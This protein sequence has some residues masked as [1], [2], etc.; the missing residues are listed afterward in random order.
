MYKYFGFGLNIASEIEMPE[1][2][3]A[4]FEVH[5]ILISIGT[6]PDSVSEEEVFSKWFFSLGKSEYILKIKDIARYYAK[7]GNTIIIQPDANVEADL[8][9][10]RVFLLGSVMGV[11]LHQRGR[12]PMHASAIS[13][14]GQLILFMG[15]SGAGKS[16][17][18]ANLVKSGYNAFTD[19]ICILD[20]ADNTTVKGA[21]AYPLIK[22]WGDAV[23][24]VDEEMFNTDYNLRPNLQKYGQFFHDKFD[25]RE[26]PVSKL[27]ILNP[28]NLVNELTCKELSGIEAFKAVEKQAYRY[29]LLTGNTM[30]PK[31]FAIISALLQNAP[32]YEITRPAQSQTAKQVLDTIKAII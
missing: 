1:L 30:R 13:K 8:K 10:V 17:L 11:V 22:L 21:A 18:L 25:K 16:T 19:D 23:K 15:D 3:P 6:V 24:L 28:S 26:L 2:V 12:L 20:N 4:D 27:F 7:D 5:D 29:R 31:H 32:V 14:D 9:S